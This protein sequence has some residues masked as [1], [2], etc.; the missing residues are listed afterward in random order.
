MVARPVPKIVKVIRGNC[1]TSNLMNSEHKSIARAPPPPLLKV[2][3]CRLGATK[4]LCELR[5]G[6]PILRSPGDKIHGD[7]PQSGVSYCGT[8]YF[9]PSH[10]QDV[11]ANNP[12]MAQIIAMTPRNRIREL[13]KARR[14][15]QAELAE[16][17]G[18]SQPAISQIEND[19]RPLSLDWMRVFARIFDCAPADLM[20]DGDNPDRLSEEERAL[21]DNFRK[22]SAQQRA[23]LS[24]ISEPFDED[25]GG[26]S[27]KK[28]G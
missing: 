14:I 7:I 18:I 5:L 3:D 13:R 26:G 21:I 23:M 20:D 19:T 15:S 1:P 10:K 17:A 11:G 27:F 28:T 16:L 12:R 4:A 22:A 8:L 25:P 2:R 9:C 6:K 24:R